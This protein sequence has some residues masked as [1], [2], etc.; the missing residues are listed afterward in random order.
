MED[1]AVARRPM[2][3]P[4]ELRRLMIP[5][6]L[7][8]LL[9]MTVGMAATVMISKVGEAAVSGVSLVDT[10]NNL[11]ISI[12]AALCTGGAVVCAQ[13]LGRQD[14]QNARGAAKQLFYIALLFA[15][16]IS[17]ALLIAPGFFIR[18]LFGEV[19]AD[20]SQSAVTYLV[21]TSLS[22]P[23]LAVY[24]ACAA[25]FR[26]MGNSR[27]SLIASAIMNVINICIN[28]LLIYG[29]N[30]GVRGAGLATLI[31]RAVAAILILIQIRNPANVIHLREFWKV[32]FEKRIVS[33][34][35][36]VGIPNGF[37][38][39]MFNFGKIIVQA[40][41]A[42]LGTAAIAANAVLNSVSGLVIVPGMGMGLA[43]VTVIGQC[44]GARDY[45]QAQSYVKKMML[46]TY[47]F[48]LTTNIPMLL[49]AKWIVALFP[50][51]TDAVATC[52]RVMPVMAILHMTIWPFAFAFPN[53]LRAA[54]D[55]RYTMICSSASM[56]LVRVGLSYVLI[57]GF[58]LGVTGVWYAM[59]ID[60]A[61]RICLFVPRY[62]SGKW[63][64]KRVIK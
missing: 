12:L 55:A 6:M 35:L 15:L 37:E 19:S 56:W 49:G 51:S 24:N 1:V 46:F 57:I 34:I 2:F 47:A 43:M 18:I 63:M 32:K 41:V 5:L 48:M 4:V 36:A 27:V 21:L 30:W 31:S 14:A 62:K 40:L 54:G 22:F 10:L 8:Q 45:E 23:F 59:F 52:L 64:T 16:V 17:A 13:Y 38:N 25:L 33:S 53:A 28:A 50:L 9:A 61:V 60:W 39:G 58:G 26:S 7:E 3:T 11:I 29:L 44:V 42:T 20:V